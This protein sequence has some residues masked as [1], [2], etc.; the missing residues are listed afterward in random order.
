[1]RE[2][3]VSGKVLRYIAIGPINVFRQRVQ[4]LMTNALK[5]LKIVLRTTKCTRSTKN[6]TTTKSGVFYSFLIKQRTNINYYSKLKPRQTKLQLP[7][8]TEKNWMLYWKYWDLTLFEVILQNQ[9][10]LSCKSSTELA[11]LSFF[12][13]LAVR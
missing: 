13:F 6:Y 3:T 12:F 7:Q 1:M 4:I 10:M 5:F 11:P 9:T 2:L 8:I